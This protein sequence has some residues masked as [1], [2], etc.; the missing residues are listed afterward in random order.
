MK[1]NTRH[2]AKML[3]T[4]GDKYKKDHAILFHYNPA[5]NIH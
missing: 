2:E 3:K 1:Y 4:K 5:F